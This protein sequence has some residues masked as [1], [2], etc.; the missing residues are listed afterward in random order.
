MKR[1]I[2]FLILLGDIAAVILYGLQ[3]HSTARVFNFGSNL[4]QILPVVPVLVIPYLL[5]LPF[6]WLTILYSFWTN[7]RFVA[8]SMAHLTSYL[9]AVAIFTNFQSM[10]SRPPVLGSDVFSQMLS[11]LYSVDAPYNAFPSLHVAMAVVVTAY[12]AVVKS[13]Y[14]TAVAVFSVVVI[15]ST[16]LLKQHY[17]VDIVG[18]LV[19]GGLS[20]R[21]SFLDF[22]R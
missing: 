22:K 4:D 9:I 1:G 12:F 13:R 5:F 18:G 2:H 16:V 15:A 20:S 21:L 19:L 3:N 8:L 10:V 7:K 6:Y 11:W 17:L 14:F